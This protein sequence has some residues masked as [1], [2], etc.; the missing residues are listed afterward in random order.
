MRFEPSILALQIM[1]AMPWTKTHN[2]KLQKKMLQ[3]HITYRSINQSKIFHTFAFICSHPEVEYIFK[4][5]FLK[6]NNIKYSIMKTQWRCRCIFKLLDRFNDNIINKIVHIC[7]VSI[8]L[9]SSSNID[10]TRKTINLMYT[11]CIIKQLRY[12]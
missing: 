9:L 5:L 8:Q 2:L 11:P 7:V 4:I 12:K 10:T 3:T 1:F 6:W